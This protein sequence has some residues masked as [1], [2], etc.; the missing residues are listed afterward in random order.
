MESAA[1]N[2]REA[3]WNG[4]VRVR[5]QLIKTR[6]ASRSAPWLYPSPF[7]HCCQSAWGAPEF[8]RRRLT[9]NQEHLSQEHLSRRLFYCGF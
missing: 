9:L 7:D 5:Q 8:V 1:C 3:L 2:Y 6:E 4:Q